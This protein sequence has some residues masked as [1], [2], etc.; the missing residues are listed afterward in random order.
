MCLFGCSKDRD[1][2]KMVTMTIYPETGCGMPILSPYWIDALIY[3]E[4][5]DKQKQMLLSTMTEGFDFKYEKGYE[6][7]FKAMKVWMSNPPMDVSSIKYIFVGPLIKK[8]IIVEN[9]EEEIELLVYSET[10]QYVPCF[11]NE[12]D[13]YGN[14][15]IYDALLVKETNSPHY[16]TAVLK[17]IEGFDF[18]SGYEYILNVKRMTQA[19]PYLLRYILLDTKDKQK[20]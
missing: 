17:E 16:W 3:S 4:S 11:P 15:K 5:D 13:E 6:Y 20:K 19:N 14:I 1:K 7:T 18:E 12:Y 10:V 8:K 2:V 9:S